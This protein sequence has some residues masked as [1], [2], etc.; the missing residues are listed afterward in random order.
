MQ[1]NDKIASIKKHLGR[2][3][4]ERMQTENRLSEIAD[5]IKLIEDVIEIERLKLQ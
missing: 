3:N 4:F 2:L 1:E 5:S